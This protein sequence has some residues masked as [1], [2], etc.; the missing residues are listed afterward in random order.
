MSL[1][2]TENKP[3]EI[4]WRAKAIADVKSIVH[5]I[6]QYSTTAAHNQRQRIRSRIESVSE[7]PGIG[8]PA[9]SNAHAAR[10]VRY[11]TEGRYYIYY[12]VV[13]TQLRILRVRHTSR[14]ILENNID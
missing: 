1:Q 13:G 12:E 11:T 4:V 7:A 2:S 10:G 9:Q 14:D 6:S 5:Y 8:K 3:L